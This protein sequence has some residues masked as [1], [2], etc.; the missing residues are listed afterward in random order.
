[1]FWSVPFCFISLRQTVLLTLDLGWQEAGP[2]DLL[3]L[4]PLGYKQDGRVR[5]FTWVPGTHT[6]GLMF[7][8]LLTTGP[9][10]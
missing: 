4:T 5:S 7:V 9:P 3:S 2:S 10:S 6:Q 8:Q 1:M